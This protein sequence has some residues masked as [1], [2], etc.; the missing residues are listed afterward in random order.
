MLWAWTRSSRRSRLATAEWFRR[1]PEVAYPSTCRDRMRRKLQTK[2]GR[3][4]YAL[5]MAT[6]E[7]VF[8]QIKAGRG[9][10]QFLLRGLDKVNGEWSLICTGHNLLKLFRLVLQSRIR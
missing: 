8:G 2:R 7:P 5:R 4:R 6:V 9:F 3:Q 10:R 1:R